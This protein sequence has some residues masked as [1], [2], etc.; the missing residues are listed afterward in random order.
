MLLDYLCSSVQFRSWLNTCFPMIIMQ[1]RA[2]FL[3]KK[4]MFW[5]SCASDGFIL[6]SY[7]Q[8]CKKQLSEELYTQCKLVMKLYSMQ[9]SEEIIYSS[10]FSSQNPARL[11]MV[12]K[13]TSYLDPNTHI[14]CTPKQIRNLY[15]TAI[16]L[17]S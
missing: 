15:N 6:L 8:L 2:T 11:V 17:I 7:A 13:M 4:M 12:I 5:G 9:V 3:V 10:L 1:Q 14:F 16:R